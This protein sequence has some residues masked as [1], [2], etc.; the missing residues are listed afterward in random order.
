MMTPYLGYKYKL[1]ACM[2]KP[3]IFIAVLIIYK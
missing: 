3:G 2:V 1:R